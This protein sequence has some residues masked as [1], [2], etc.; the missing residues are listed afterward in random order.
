MENEKLIGLIQEILE[1]GD[2]FT[3]TQIKNEIY[4]KALYKLIGDVTLTNT[5]LYEILIDMSSKG[6]IN[7]K[8]DMKKI[9]LFSK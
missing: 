7:H 3:T 4:K 1:N 2:T 8:E 9:N 6:I 5:F